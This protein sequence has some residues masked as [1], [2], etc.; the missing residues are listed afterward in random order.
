MDRKV[1]LKLVPAVQ[2]EHKKYHM[3]VCPKCG[4]IKI[5]LEKGE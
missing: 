2:V 1:F 3:Y 4:A 5:D